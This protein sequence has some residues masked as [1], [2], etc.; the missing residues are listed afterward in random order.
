MSTEDSV[1]PGNYGMLDQVRALEWVRDNIAGFN[2]DPNKVTIF[3][4]SAGA[5][6]T[7]LLMLSPKAKGT[8]PIIFTS[9]LQ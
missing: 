9:Y 4:Q 8:I 5:A 1:S 2:G 7:G 3:G 6:S